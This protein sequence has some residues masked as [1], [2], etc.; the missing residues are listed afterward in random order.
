MAGGGQI[1]KDHM[2]LCKITGKIYIGLFP[3]FLHRAPKSFEISLVRGESFVLM[4]HKLVGFW[5]ISGCELVTR[6]N[7]L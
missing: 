2:H 7:K 4:R 5:T 1:R 3:Q 6:K